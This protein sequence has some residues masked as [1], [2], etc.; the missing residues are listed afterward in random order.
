M[1][2]CCIPVV[3][4]LGFLRGGYKC[5]FDCEAFNS[6]MNADKIHQ[7]K[8]SMCLCISPKKNIKSNYL[9]TELLL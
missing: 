5:H 1:G 6:D 4:K 9:N 2:K 8:G 7:M 3:G